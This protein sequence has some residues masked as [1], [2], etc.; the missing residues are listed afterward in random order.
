MS[1]QTKKYFT[2]LL[3]RAIAVLTAFAA[4]MF[5]ATAADTFDEFTLAGLSF[6]VISQVDVELIAS[7]DSYKGVLAVNI[8]ARV[9]FEGKSYRLNRIAPGAFQGCTTLR[10]ITI[11]TTIETIGAHAFDGC[12]S[13]KKIEI[14]YTVHSLGDYTFYN[15]TKL[16][17]V[18][19]PYS[20]QSIGKRSFA[21]C[22]SLKSLIL[23]AVI[24]DWFAFEGC[25]ALEDIDLGPRVTELGVG[26]FKD[27]TKLSSFTIP[28]SVREVD[29]SLFYNCA[30]LK[31]ITIGSNVDT[32]MVSA[33]EG[34]DALERF[35]VNPSNQQYS[36]VNGIL[37][38]Y[39]HS[40]LYAYPAGRDEE[41]LR[42]AISPARH[43]G[44]HAFYRNKKIRTV[45]LST[46]VKF[47]DEEAFAECPNLERF[48]MPFTL[49]IVRSKA[50]R[51]C[52]NLQYVRFRTM[53]DEIDDDV[54]L[55]CDNLTDFHCR[56]RNPK[57]VTIGE[58]TFAGL[59][60]NCVLFVP[61]TYGETYENT[62][63]WNTGF[64]KIV[65]EDVY[66]LGDVNDDEM[67][68]S[69]D[70]SILYQYLL[71]PENTYLDIDAADINHD[72][73]I[74]TSDISELYIV[75]LTTDTD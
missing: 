72:G 33:F 18:T 73:E 16:S 34:C 13:L 43:I 50:L 4:T 3:H 36:A 37:C 38:D 75:I 57:I 55:G 52:K 42:L 12:T 14:P 21:G 6:R 11:P 54:F 65:E 66:V 53:I 71:D 30:S 68:N 22:T 64:S 59:P 31:E 32:V 67:C 26:A 41:D 61:L 28:E 5:T 60:A 49:G 17:S 35:I 44:R 20:V 15:C 2:N 48:D 70:I 8:P 58:R 56:H 51:D 69:S 10:S 9:S 63:G 23:N 27:C 1:R 62:P 45:K 40:I 29:D 25:T 24:V 39:G 47:I 74:N 7:N 46:N 19:L